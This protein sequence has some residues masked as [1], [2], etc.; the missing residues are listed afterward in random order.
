MLV[1]SCFVNISFHICIL[2]ILD[3]AHLQT[4]NGIINDGCGKDA[5][6]EY[7]SLAVHPED[8]AKPDHASAQTSSDAVW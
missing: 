7:T 3:R 5:I 6:V 1:L 4:I 8:G 2:G